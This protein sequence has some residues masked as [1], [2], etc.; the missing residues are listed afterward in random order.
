MP[1]DTADP[2]RLWP[3]PAQ[4]RGRVRW[5]DRELCKEVGAV[6]PVG[7][8]LSAAVEG[9]VVSVVRRMGGDHMT[10]WQG[11]QGGRGSGWGLVSSCG[12]RLWSRHT[13]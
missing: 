9:V 13:R 11:D 7:A 1:K 2:R 8:E 4:C 10:R 5:R 3:S 12:A 6:M